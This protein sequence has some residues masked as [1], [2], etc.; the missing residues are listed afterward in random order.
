MYEMI[1]GRQPGAEALLGLLHAVHPIDP[2][3][4]RDAWIEADT[5]GPVIR[6]HTRNGGG[7]RDTQAPSITSYQSHP[8]YVRDEDDEFDSTY[9]DFYFRPAPV[10]IGGGELNQASIDELCSGA[11]EHVNMRERWETAIEQLGKQ[12]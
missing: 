7:N 2:G 5:G 3:R 8:W 1:F 9:A 10:Q 11:V 4:F 6:V 12:S